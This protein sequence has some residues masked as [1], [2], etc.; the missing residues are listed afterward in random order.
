MLNEELLERYSRQILLP[1]ID[2]VGQENILQASVLVVGCGGLGSMVSMF[3]AGAGVGKLILVDTDSVELSNLHRQLAFRESDIDQ[4]K[5]QALKNQLLA[6]NSEIKVT[7]ATSRFGD[8]AESDAE[9]LR[10][11][12]IVIDAT[13][14]L[15]S[16]HKI[17]RLTRDAK[18]PWIMGS[19]T[20]LHGQVVAFSQSRAEGCYQCLAPSEDD[21]R[22]FDCR[23]EGILGPVIGVIAAW[24]AQDALMFLSGQ[25]LEWGILRVYDATQQR[26]DRLVV[27]PRDGCHTSYSGVKPVGIG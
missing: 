25:Q 1:E 9:L 19:A 24:Q 15:A 10:D 21:R 22:G 12:D 13:D 26:I 2:L 18:K 11:T 23:N 3:L 5:A 7:S 6:L 17:E 4:P 14:N 8:D 27:T 16:R 20:R